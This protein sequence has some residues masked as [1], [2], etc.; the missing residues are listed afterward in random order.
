MSTAD[1]GIRVY[2]QDAASQ[3]FRNI[4]DQMRAMSDVTRLLTSNWSDLNG[5]MVQT[6]AIAGLGLAFA[7][8]TAAV[9]ASIQGASQFQSTLNDV[10][11]ATNATNDQMSQ[12]Q[13]VMMNLGSSSIFSLEQI[14]QGFILLGQRGQSA[15][16]IM[17]YVGQAGINL[18]EA[19]GVEPVDAMGLL[20]SVMSA[21]K[22]P[23]QDAA[24]V[25]NLLFYAFEN[26]VPNVGQLTSGCSYLGS[27]I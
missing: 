16:A 15:A 7:G 14:A 23:A 27:L 5:A 13:D 12:M 4:G 22:I 6:A 18:A 20:S 21:Y 9:V 17:N 11:F 1:I 10:Q 8:L 25:S 2:L 19:I 24:Q 3:G 26:G